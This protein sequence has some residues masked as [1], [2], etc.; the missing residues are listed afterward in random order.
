MT[1]PASFHP[2][3]VDLALAERGWLVPLYGSMLVTD[4]AALRGVAGI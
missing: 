3:D 1:Q 2:A 4:R